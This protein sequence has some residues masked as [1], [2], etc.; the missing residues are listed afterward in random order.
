[1][2]WSITSTLIHVDHSA[3]RTVVHSRPPS[4]AAGAP[5]GHQGGQ[6]ADLRSEILV[7]QFT[8]EV[9]TRVDACWPWRYRGRVHPAYERPAGLF[10]GPAHSHSTQ[11]HHGNIFL[12]DSILDILACFPTF[13]GFRFLDRR[14]PP[15]ASRSSCWSR[16]CSI[17]VVKVSRVAPR[18]P[19][20][21]GMMLYLPLIHKNTMG[22]PGVAREEPSGISRGVTHSTF[23]ILS[24]R[25]MVT[26]VEFLLN[27]KGKPLINF[28]N[29][30]FFQKLKTLRQNGDQETDRA[31]ESG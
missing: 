24:L 22:W 17:G 23:P 4:Q 8:G 6:N 2:Y 19:G 13:S 12:Q 27:Y 30:V 10:P 31:K 26:K 14:R 18:R 25:Y 3:C 5:A 29:F 7:F 21:S 11:E 15:L 20:T 1:M 9:F 28:R 16:R